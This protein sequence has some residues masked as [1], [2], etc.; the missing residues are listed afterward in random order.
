MEMNER[1]KRKYLTNILKSYLSVSI[2]LMEYYKAAADTRK[3]KLVCSRSI[4]SL[5]EAMDHLSQ[6]KHIEILDYLY[7]SFIGNNAIAYS[8]S[9]KIVNSQKLKEYDTD[10]GFEEFKKVLEEQRKEQ[11]EREK[12]RKES[13]E[14]LKKAKE[15]G[16]KVEMVYDKDT[17]TTK[18]M[19][20]EDKE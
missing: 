20:V 17:K 18:P 11:E 19:I 3:G 15:M 5:N 8:V 9:G 2:S 16:K 1:K 13:M 7:A 10:K 14:A 12:K 4:K 6:I